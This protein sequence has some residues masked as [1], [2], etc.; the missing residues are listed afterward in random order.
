MNQIELF[1]LGS[2]QIGSYD[3]VLQRFLRKKLRLL[4]PHTIAR[5]YYNLY[6]LSCELNNPVIAG[7]CRR[8]VDGHLAAAWLRLAP[9]TMRTKTADLRQ[10]LKWCKRKKYIK[11]NLG[12][13]LKSVRKRSRRNRRSKAAAE[14]DVFFLMDCLAAM[15]RPFLFRDVFQQLQIKSDYRIC[16]QQRQ[17]LRDLFV[18]V[19]LYETG[20]RAGELANLSSKAMNLAVGCKSKMYQITVIGKTNDRDYLFT[21]RTAELWRLWYQQSLRPRAIIIKSNGI[22][23]MLVRR[24]EQFGIRPFR[25]HALRHAKV[26]R[27]RRLVGLETTRILID[28]SRLETTRGY[29]YFDEAEMETA[30]LKTGLRT[31]FFK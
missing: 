14:D 25:S 22:S 29:D 15:L 8:D 3:D 12:K 28:H 21:D 23:Q 4:S 18:L 17:A 19:F 10:F 16:F 2:Y 6:P 20:A 26:K 27:S 7:L 9:E 5:L 30:V 1:F 31:D 13:H 24:C 11:R